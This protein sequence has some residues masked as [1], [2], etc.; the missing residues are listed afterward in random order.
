MLE[1][2]RKR[3][4]IEGKVALLCSQCDCTFH[5]CHSQAAVAKRGKLGMFCSQACMSTFRRVGSDLTCSNCKGVFH[6]CPAEQ[7][8]SSH[9]D[10]FC[11]RECYREH[12]AANRSNNTYLKDGER[13]E[14]RVVAEKV[15]NRPL[16]SGEVV[17]H[18]DKDKQNNSPTNLCVFPSQSEHAKWHMEI[19]WHGRIISTSLLKY[20]LVK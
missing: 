9:V 8:K 11:S 3:H 7:R 13:H 17:H 2:M 15:L 14:H 12:A 20:R 4:R 18:I 16:L 1:L 5:K 6:R 19:R 10:N